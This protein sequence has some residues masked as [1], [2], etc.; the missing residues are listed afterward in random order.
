MTGLTDRY[1]AALKPSN[2]QRITIS[3]RG[4]SGVRGLHLMVNIGG[5]KVF[6]FRYRTPAGKQKRIKIGSY[7]ATSLIKARKKAISYQ[8]EIDNGN[9]PSNDNAMSVLKRRKYHTISDLWDDYHQDALTRK[10]SAV[11]EKRMW[12]K[13]LEHHFGNMDIRKFTRETVLDFII[14][15]RKNHSPS[16][17][18]KIQAILTP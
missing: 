3:D 8:M 10:K 9:E 4:T 16:L 17:S 7:P 14:P 5:S 15:Y 12:H 2:K 18:A 6:Y 13:H 11:D 1:I